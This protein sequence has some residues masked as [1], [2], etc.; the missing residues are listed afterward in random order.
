[1]VSCTKVG[2]EFQQQIT[3]KTSVALSHFYENIID[4]GY[5]LSCALLTGSIECYSGCLI[6]HEY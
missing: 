6:R 3:I 5:T 1:M 2:V 4:T